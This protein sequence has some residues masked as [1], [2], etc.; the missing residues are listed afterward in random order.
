MNKMQVKGGI[1]QARPHDSGH[2]HVT[3]EA[4]YIDDIAEPAG[5][6]HAYLGLSKRPHAEI[7]SMDLESVREAGAS[8][9][10]S[11]PKTFRA[12]TIFPP[13]TCMTSRS[14]PKE[15]VE[16]WG[17]PLFAV[18]AETREQARRAAVLAMIEYRDLPH[19]I[20]IDAAEAAGGK[21]VTAPLKLERGEIAA[22]A[23]EGAP[24]AQG[25][26]DHWRA[27]AFLSRRPD[28]HGHSRRG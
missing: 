25:R 18:I 4:E 13:R 14:L 15:L 23:G 5:T 6:L 9:P 12:T 22:G 19:A 17:Q 28:F 20:S 8:S 21:F 11:P 7:L 16:F 3:G 1:H 2:K 27:G 24:A 10:C 26:D